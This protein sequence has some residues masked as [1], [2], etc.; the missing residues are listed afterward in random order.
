MRLLFYLSRYPGWGGIETVTYTVIEELLKRG[1][2]IDILSHKQQH[3]AQD[4]PASV[5]LF[6]MP[7]T[8]A[9]DTKVN[10]EFAES[11]VKKNTYD[12]IVYQDC[13]EPNE[14]LIVDVST[15]C[16]I[17]FILFEH[18][19]PL[20][21]YK[22]K[23]LSDNPFKR[24]I[25]TIIYPLLQQRNLHRERKRKRFL[26][27]N[28]TKYVL[29][30]SKYI[31]EIA[32]RIKIPINSHN[33]FSNIPN[34]IKCEFTENNKKCKELLFVGRLV[35]EKQIDKILKI[36]KRLQNR[37]PEWVLSIVGDGPLRLELEKFVKHNDINRVHFYGYQNPKEFYRRSEIFLMTSRFE[38][39]GMTLLEAMSQGCVPVVENNFSA[40]SDIIDNRINGIVIPA[41]ASV[42]KWSNLLSELMDNH[43]LLA[44]MSKEGSKT[45][46]KYS[47]DKIIDRWEALLTKLK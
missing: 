20:L 39:W 10:R 28:C 35:K 33:K 44:T 36:W 26:Y 41:K 27:D 24:F 25:Q 32:K 31:P 6:K 23:F 14:E 11:I 38:G 40:L 42:K 37:Y 47:I 1:H 45:I 17:P 34:P 21:L 16:G 4:I 7:D 15:K 8:S 18:N 3:E 2:R 43:T 30:S 13:Y 12:L 22:M 5:T 9:L 19:T 46:Q 29:L